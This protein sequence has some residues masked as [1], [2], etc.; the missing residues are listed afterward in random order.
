M[1]W[2]ILRSH[3]LEADTT[4]TSRLHIPST[5]TQFLVNM[6]Q[7]PHQLLWPEVRQTIVWAN[8]WWNSDSSYVSKTCFVSIRMFNSF[9]SRFV[10][11]IVNCHPSFINDSS[12]WQMT[13]RNTITAILFLL[14]VSILLQWPEQRLLCMCSAHSIKLF[15][16]CHPH[17][18]WLVSIIFTDLSFPQDVAF[19]AL[20][21]SKLSPWLNSHKH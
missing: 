18:V 7:D 16:A 20:Y 9:P 13:S 15:S 11:Q 17:T 2:S 4:A 3:E 1:T 14:I 5:C 8:A 21:L 19:C 10:R 12:L 6:N